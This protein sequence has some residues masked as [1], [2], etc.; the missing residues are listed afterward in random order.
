VHAAKGVSLAKIQSAHDGASEK[1]FPGPK[2]VPIA[3]VGCGV[4]D[5]CFYWLPRDLTLL[6]FA[7]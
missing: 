5:Y 6:L 3:V 4:W 1:E 2:E 7:V